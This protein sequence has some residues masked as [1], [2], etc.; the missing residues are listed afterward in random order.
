[1]TGS[2]TAGVCS[3]WGVLA[4]SAKV[5]SLLW[6]LLLVAATGT[7]AAVMGMPLT[8]ADGRGLLQAPLPV[9]IAFAFGAWAIGRTGS[10]R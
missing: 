7:T 8:T 2:A 9:L 4:I 10:P 6:L 5:R 1:V 3:S